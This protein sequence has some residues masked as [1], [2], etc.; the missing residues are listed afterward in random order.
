MDKGRLDPSKFLLS[1]TIKYG[2]SFFKLLKEDVDHIFHLLGNKIKRKEVLD[3]VFQSPF[4]FEFD[5]SL[6][7]E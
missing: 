3:F 4:R 5:E 7:E 6:D 1:N 2:K